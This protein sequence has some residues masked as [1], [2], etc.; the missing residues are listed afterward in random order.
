MPETLPLAD[1]RIVPLKA[2]EQLQW[3]VA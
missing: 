1:G 3:Q 2:G